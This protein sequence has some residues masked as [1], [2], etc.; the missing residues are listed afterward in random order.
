MRRLLLAGLAVAALTAIPPRPGRALL[1]VGDIVF[2]PAIHA[3]TLLLVQQSFDQLENLKEGLAVARDTYALADK[4][5]R[6][7][8]VVS[9]LAE[10]GGSG[11]QALLPVAGEFSAA[12]AG[13]EGAGP[14]SG[15]L[16]QFIQ[17]DTL[18]EPEEDSFGA[19]EIVRRRKALSGTKAFQQSVYD[20][21]NDRIGAMRQIQIA[22]LTAET[23]AQKADVSRR[24]QEE[25]VKIAALQTQVSLAAD[26]AAA[27]REDN[28]QR[29]REYY[30]ELLDGAYEELLKV[31]HTRFNRVGS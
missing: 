28:E 22:S 5:F 19:R 30:R 15:L 10:R 11:W 26:R 1:G 16:G 8:N 23:E 25:Q 12:L 17:Q 18:Y 20:Q 3:E 2:D 29:K 31:H 14:L 7:A 6:A 9:G 24:Y 4:A 21:V 27:E 13:R